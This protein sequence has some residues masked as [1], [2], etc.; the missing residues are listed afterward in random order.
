[1][2]IETKNQNENSDQNDLNLK[3]LEN[4]INELR[5]FKQDNDKI[6]WVFNGQSVEKTLNDWLMEALKKV[7]SKKIQKIIDKIEN[8]YKD[9][10]LNLDDSIKKDL[11][12]LWS[13]LSWILIQRNNEK[14]QEF[15]KQSFDKFKSMIE[16]NQL[17]RLNTLKNKEIEE[18]VNFVKNPNNKREVFYL[19]PKMKVAP[20]PENFKSTDEKFFKVVLNAI[21]DT[22][23]QIDDEDAMKN[24]KLDEAFKDVK[25]AKDLANLVHIYL[26][27]SWNWENLNLD[28]AKNLDQKWFLGNDFV[29]KFNE[30]NTERI[31]KNNKLAEDINL[32]FSEDLMKNF[33]I[34]WWELKYKGERFDQ[35]AMLKYFSDSIMPSLDEWDFITNEKSDLVSKI[36]NNVSEKIIAKLKERK[37]DIS[38]ELW[39]MDDEDFVAMKNKLDDKMFIEIKDGEISY[40]PKK[41]KDYLSSL[42]NTE[43]SELKAK[44]WTPEWRAWVS[45]VQILLNSQEW[46]KIIV[47]GKFG[48]ETRDRVQAFQEKYNENIPEW[49]VKLGVDGL[50]WK[51]TIAVLLDGK[52]GDTIREWEWKI[53]ENGKVI[54]DNI[55]K[56][57]DEKTGRMYIEIDNGSGETQRYYEYRKGMN[58]LW[59]RSGINN[60]NNWYL[61]IWNF[62]NGNLDWKWI[63]E[64][65][66]W[67]KYE[68][69]WKNDVME[70]QGT[71]TWADWGKYEWNWKNGKKEWQGTYTWKIWNKIKWNWE[72]NALYGNAKV[73]L[74]SDGAE[75]DVT[76]N[77]DKELWEVTTEWEYKGKFISS[78]TWEFVNE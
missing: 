20:K 63:V 66:D 17:D 61:C 68:W 45:A 24:F 41:A 3:K 13:A 42:R 6:E 30:I 32:D 70:W 67:D 34:E 27:I 29:K 69:N 73:T 65:A 62:K 38:D 37:Q 28:Y 40:D 12:V 1:M 72:N 23:P 56:N 33:T 71:Y 54:F 46:D 22:Y 49:A 76:W 36:Y 9:P 15:K 75:I 57:L 19:Y 58:G 59:Y 50:P 25:S 39:W 77:T 53:N 26:W 16:N 43:W 11:Q 52:I 64:W 4:E 35:N 44:Y 60:K 74:K 2:T 51:D 10:T 7:D 8:V 78:E 47:D 55:K 21:K 31:S 14:D 18:V 5:D 48:S